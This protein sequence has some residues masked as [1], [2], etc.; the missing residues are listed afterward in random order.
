MRS[1]STMMQKKEYLI[2]EAFIYWFTL[3][4]VSFDKTIKSKW[5]HPIPFNTSY[6]MH[7]E[8]WQNHKAE[9]H[10]SVSHLIQIFT[11][12]QYYLMAPKTK[13]RWFGWILFEW[14]PNCHTIFLKEIF[15]IVI[16][17]RTQLIFL[18]CK[19]GTNAAEWH[20]RAF[21]TCCNQSP[22]CGYYQE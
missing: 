7:V 22:D 14:S 10:I 20:S 15:H 21:K 1:Y 8:F 3:F 5:I 17:K 6:H 19:Y 11:H 12:M 13:K 9:F 4:L 2:R 16:I 18:T